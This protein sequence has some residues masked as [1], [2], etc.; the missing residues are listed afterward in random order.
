M[1]RVLCKLDDASIETL[2]YHYENGNLLDVMID[3]TGVWG[4][5][6]EAEETRPPLPPRFPDV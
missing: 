2:Q 6:L 5:L 3:E 4:V 1:M